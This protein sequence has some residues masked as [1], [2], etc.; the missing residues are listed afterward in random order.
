MT[1]ETNQECSD[2][3][4]LGISAFYHDSAASLINNG[5]IIAAAQ[6]ERFTRRKHDRS[7]PFSAINYCLEE[8]EIDFSDIDYVV[9]YDNPL[10]KF[11]RIIS[12]H[13]TV[14]PQGTEQWQKMLPRLLSTNLSLPEI[15]RKH[16][17]GFKGKF[18]YGNHHLSHAS[19]A[20]FPSPFQKSAILTID[21]VGEWATATIITSGFG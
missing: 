19:S 7:F 15:I 4:I 8:A 6:E 10:I 3:F 9:F 17:P 13:L 21:G 5:N 18:F 20:F 16:M 14:Y 2:C 12:N 1:P 11:E